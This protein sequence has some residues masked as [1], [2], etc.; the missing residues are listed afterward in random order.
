MADDKKVIFSI[1]AVNAEFNSIEDF[2]KSAAEEL[3]QRYDVTITSH[4]A[5]VKVDGQR[6]YRMDYYIK[7]KDANQC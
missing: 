3:D 4:G 2:Y 6:A 1:S 5:Q 7:G